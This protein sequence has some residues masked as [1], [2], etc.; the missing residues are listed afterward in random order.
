MSYREHRSEKWAQH[1]FKNLL[2]WLFVY[3]LIGPFLDTIPSAQLVMAIF[4]SVVLF[5]AVYA[6]NRTSRRFSIVLA[7]VAP[8]LL[9]L[10]W[11]TFHRVSLAASLSLAF[12]I[13]FLGFVVFS[14]ARHLFGA[15]RVD[16]NVICAAL[17]L[18]LI[19]GLWWGYLFELLELLVPGSFV[20]GALDQAASIRE[21]A[22]SLQYF[23]FVTLSTLGYGDIVPQTPGA[24]ALCRAEAILGQFFALVL[25]A[26]LVGIQVA[27]ELNS[28]P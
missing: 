21:K 16:A 18:Y 7:L 14:F 11:S 13:G 24:Q 22:T 6:I 5:S 27:Q 26:R 15:R 8:T 2:V 25:V 28:E 9:L 10:W 4:L 3:M 23:S 12:L 20:G 1:G 19:F 17:C